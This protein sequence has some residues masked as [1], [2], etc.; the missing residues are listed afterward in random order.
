V[1]IKSSTILSFA[2]KL[3]LGCSLEK[4]YLLNFLLCKLVIAKAS[5][6]ANCTLV[7]E[8]GTIPNPDSLTSGIYNFISAAL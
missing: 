3:P 1:I 4:S 8:V 6:I 5:P 7:L 2:P